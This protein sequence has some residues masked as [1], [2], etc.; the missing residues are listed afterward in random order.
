MRREKRKGEREEEERE[1][2][3][4]GYEKIADC[5]RVRMIKGRCKGSEERKE[6]K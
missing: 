3:G 6:R 4:R 2:E 5:G 1:G